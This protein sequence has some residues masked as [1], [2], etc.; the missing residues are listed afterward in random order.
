[1]I[2]YEVWDDLA[3]FLFYRNRL[4][5]S[6]GQARDIKPNVTTQSACFDLFK[7]SNHC[8]IPLN[9]SSKISCHPSFELLDALNC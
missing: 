9:R 2:V 8:P 4:S 3:P 1:M 7:V 5:L 6:L